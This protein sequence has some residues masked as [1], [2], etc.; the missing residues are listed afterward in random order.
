MPTR[1][2]LHPIPSVIDLP[3]SPTP[4]AQASVSLPRF[5]GDGLKLRNGNGA[6]G[7]VKTLGQGF[8]EKGDVLVDN[9]DMMGNPLADEP[10]GRR[11]HYDAD[12]A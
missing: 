4:S 3:L 6:T 8:S 5:G 7:T 11:K 1:S 2:G 12:G 9:A 10:E